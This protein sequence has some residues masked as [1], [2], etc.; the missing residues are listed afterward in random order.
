M[1]EIGQIKKVYFLGIGGIGMSGL[2]LFLLKQ[3]KQVFGYDLTPSTVT[4]SLSDQGAVIH[5]TEDIEAI[6]AGID[7]VVLT[8]AIPKSHKELIYFQENRIPIVK[9]SELLGIICKGFPVV[10]VSGSHGKTTTTSMTTHL[11]HSISHPT[12]AFIGGISQ[13]LGSNLLY[14]ADYQTIVVEADEFDRSFLTLYPRIGVITSMDADHLD[15]YGDLSHM[16]AAFQEFTNQID[17][18]GALVI[19]QSVAHL[20]EHPNKITYGDTED[21]DFYFQIDHETP[22]ET[23]FSIC[24]KM[25]DGDPVC[26]HNLKMKSTGFHNLLNGLAAFLAVKELLGL[27][28]DSENRADFQA[29]FDSFETWQGVKR[30]FEYRIKSDNLVY[31]DDYAHQP[32]ELEAII[33][34][35]K[36]IYSSE[37]VV[38]VF[39]PHLYT[40][41]RDFLHEFAEALALLD[42]VILLDIY[43][44]RELPI[45]GITS[46][47]LLQLIEN[48]NK[49][50]LSKQELVPYLVNRK[51][52]VLITMGAGDIGVLVPEIEK[53]LK[54]L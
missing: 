28:M 33:N 21:A 5:Y 36:K 23:Q 9:R 13:N 20:I 19:H 27:K 15:V 41:T 17:R 40:R 6:P 26:F 29:I 14:D 25:E 4:Q 30:R 49:I 24:K 51:P 35:V 54:S 7:L 42:E 46:D 39:Q 11:L 12:L 38:G 8:P 10:A 52:K 2:A 44:A 1:L 34:A 3:G 31:I 22:V 18:T 43:P 45:E 37:K 32:Q 53:A 48:P 16:I 47:Y 50:K